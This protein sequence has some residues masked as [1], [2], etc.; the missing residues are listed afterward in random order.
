VGEGFDEPRLD[1][2][3][4]AAPISWKGTLQQYAGRLHRDY[5]GK[6]SVIIYDYVDIY[7]KMLENMY[8]KRVS[9]Y[10]G[11]G[12]KAL[13]MNKADSQEKVG[14]IFD[15]RNFMATFERDVQFAN[16]EI[17]ICGPVLQ[18]SRVMKI[19][20]LLSEAKINGVRVVVITRSVDEYDEKEQSKAS[21]LTES[22]SELGVSV[23]SKP[24][25]HQKFAVIDENIIWYGNV[26]VLG[27]SYG[28]ESL[29][30]FENADVAGELL[31]T[32]E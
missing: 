30:R 9:G 26:S 8:H 10:S 6:E 11:M 12:Y 25:I 19:M 28:E 3:F 14:I 7:V 29:M 32:V 2:L 5:D 23:I 4:L 21:A 31:A 15:N 22:L 16:R 27:F 24:N 17:V 13:S 1:T 20:K 18:K